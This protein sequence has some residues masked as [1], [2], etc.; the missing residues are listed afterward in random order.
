[1]WAISLVEQA[2]RNKIFAFLS[3]LL[4]GIGGILSTNIFWIRFLIFLG[5]LAGIF[6]IIV[7]KMSKIYGK[8]EPLNL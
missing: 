7:K 5:I 2:I 1:M 8:K 4:Q 3:L 6:P